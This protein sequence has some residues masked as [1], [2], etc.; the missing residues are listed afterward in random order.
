VILRFM[1]NQRLNSDY[2]NDRGSGNGD[3]DNRLY[4]MFISVIS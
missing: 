2:D 3:Y 1:P 4:L